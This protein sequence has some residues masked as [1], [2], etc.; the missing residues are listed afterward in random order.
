MRQE[1]I[2]FDGNTKEKSI[3][4]EFAF[5]LYDTYGFPIDLT[6]LIARRKRVGKLMRNGFNKNLQQQKERSKAAGKL[7]T[8]DWVILKEDDK[9]EF[10]GYDE[11]SSDIFITRY[12]EVKVKGKNFYQLVFNL[13]PF[14]PE[15]GGQVGDKGFYHFIGGEG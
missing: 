3:S 15:G 8:G 12:R 4:G 1:S 7:I 11:L 9:E 5:E 6:R 14:Y 10:I 2:R 13:T